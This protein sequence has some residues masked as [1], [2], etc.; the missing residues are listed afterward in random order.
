MTSPILNIPSA[1]NIPTVLLYSFTQKEQE[2]FRFLLRGFP[3]IRL[4]AVPEQA[5]DLCLHDILISPMP[6]SI[7]H[8]VFFRH[9]LVLAHIPDPLV[10]PL[11][12]ICKQATAEKVLKAMLTETNQNWT[13]RVLYKNLLDEEAQLGG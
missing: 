1:N 12:A 10:H 5:Y 13:S 6:S 3:G 4:I 2:T 11:L 7:G 9:M 8:T